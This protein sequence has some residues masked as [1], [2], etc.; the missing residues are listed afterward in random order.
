[1]EDYENDA[2]NENEDDDSPS[3]KRSY[4]EWCD[5]IK[6]AEKRTE[7]WHTMADRIVDRYKSDE[8]DTKGTDVMRLNL[9]YSN[10]STLESMLYG[11]VPKIDVSRRY[12]DADDDVSRVASEMLQ[13]MLNEDMQ[14]DNGREID[15]VLRSTLQDRL[16]AGLGVAK[17]RYNL[18]T[19][20][21][22]QGNEVITSESAPIDY[23]YWGDVLW[24]WSRN[25]TDLPWIGF[26]NYLTKEQAIERFGEEEAEQLTYD[27]RSVN[28]GDDADENVDAEDTESKQAEVWELWDKVNRTVCWLHK[29]RKVLLDHKE[30]TLK[31]KGF[32]PCPPFFL[33][34]PTT[35]LY[36]PTP[37]FK[38]SQDLYNE[39][40]LLQTR[41]SILTEAVKAVGVYDKN[42]DG[43]Q[44]MFEEGTDNTLIPVDS[45]AAF[46]EKGGIKGS[47]DWMP[48]EAIT[49]AIDRLT[50]IRNDTIGLLQQV[51]GMADV[52]RG[53]L[54][55]QYEGV[56]QTKEKSKFASVRVQALQDEFARFATDI[57]Q[58]K[59]EIISRHFSPESIIKQSRIQNT[60]EDPKNIQG[61]L[62]IIKDPANLNMSVLI[63]PESIAMLDYNEMKQE[64]MEFLRAMGDF[65]QIISPIVQGDPEAEP[66]MLEMM[67]WSLAGFKGAQ[68]VESL[69]DR[70]VEAAKKRSKDAA[71]QPKQ[72]SPEE[73]QAQ[74]DQKKMQMQA[75]IEMQKMQAKAQA[76]MQVRQQDMQADMKTAEFTHMLKMQEIQATAMAKKLENET[77]MNS[78]II[79]Q[80][81]D[82]DQNI[83]QTDAAAQAD[84][85]K[86]AFKTE[87]EI[88]KL[89]AKSESEYL[90]DVHATNMKLEE[91][92]FSSNIKKTEMLESDDK[93]ESTD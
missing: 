15:T 54:K 47:V 91:V 6:A 93:D 72:P 74:A 50:M 64:R 29:D 7:N 65:I 60:V 31:L 37:D 38:L 56:G 89:V 86:T 3:G 81:N 45:W 1:M 68:Q 40:D 75:Q 48:I 39:I 28:V 11:S 33:A 73:Q 23:Y 21:D 82:A 13:R 2:T 26:R 18:E 16:L 70:V 87:A 55:N 51:T 90:K 85:Q 52:M 22:E 67:Q 83:R 12:A 35:K 59:A 57:M 61:A 4:K 30:D 42:A 9:L 5:E 53:E 88:E 84:M 19:A 78:R 58:I 20:E 62:G 24:G 71:N 44:R 36:M 41:I 49:T 46:A 92:K 25:F 76:D 69:F 34:N 17:L 32:Y 79:E 8:A 77:R 43:V 27:V 14:S 66:F 63:R 80:Q 10:V